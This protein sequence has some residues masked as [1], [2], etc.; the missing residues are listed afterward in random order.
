M[1]TGHTQLTQASDNG[2]LPGTSDND[3]CR[4]PGNR[5]CSRVRLGTLSG[6]SVEEERRQR[7]PALRKPDAISVHG[8][9]LT[10]GGPAPDNPKTDCCTPATSGHKASHPR[11][12][13]TVAKWLTIGDTEHRHR[14]LTYP[15][16]LR[17]TAENPHLFPAQEVATAEYLRIFDPSEVSAALELSA[18]GYEDPDSEVM[19][20]SAMHLEQQAKLS[21]RGP[22][23]LKKARL[24]HSDIHD[25]GVRSRVAKGHH[26][27]CPPHCT[28]D[29]RQ[30]A[31][32]GVDHPEVARYL[33]MAGRLMGNAE[34]PHGNSESY[35]PG[36]Y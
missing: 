19:R 6:T 21:A 27:G 20:L 5:A 15:R 23:A 7:C 12:G 9:D 30:P 28:R 11:G 36:R 26:R 10:V 35:H 1:I 22:A 13:G 31:H 2:L 8:A 25:S 3:S 33:K 16:V 14:R 32:G 4:S 18:V 24:E 17:L 34:A 29:H